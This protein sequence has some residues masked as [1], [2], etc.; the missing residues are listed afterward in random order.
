MQVDIVDMEMMMTVG[1][2]FTNFWMINI[3]QVNYGMWCWFF[4][5]E[6]ISRKSEKG[7]SECDIETYLY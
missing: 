2:V 7:G 6:K 4:A 3:R 1:Q 5:R